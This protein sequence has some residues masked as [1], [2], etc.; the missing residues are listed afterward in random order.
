MDELFGRRH[1]VVLNTAMPFSAVSGIGSLRSRRFAN[2]LDGGFYGKSMLSPARAASNSS[3]LSVRERSS[4]ALWHVNV[5]MACVI[6]N[7]HWHPKAG[8]VVG[9]DLRSFVRQ[10]HLTPM[11]LP[12][13]GV[14]FDDLYFGVCH[15]RL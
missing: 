15:Y 9:A 7:F 1:Y 3:L 8:I 4:A 14:G 2:D 5:N 13:S 6:P 10:M 12:E 11:N